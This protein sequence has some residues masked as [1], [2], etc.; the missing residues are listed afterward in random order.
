MAEYWASMSFTALPFAN[1]ALK[2]ELSSK[3]GVTGIPCLIVLN[4]DGS[5]LSRDGRRLV[6]QRPEGFPAEWK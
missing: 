4:P 1:S 6:M 3:F 5:I 2:A